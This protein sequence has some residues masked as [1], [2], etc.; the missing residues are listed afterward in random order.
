LAVSTKNRRSSFER[1]LETCKN[2]VV[3]VCFD[4]GNVLVKA[5]HTWRRPVEKLGLELGRPEH[6]D[7]SVFTIP[8]YIPMEAKQ[9][10]V[11]EYLRS[12][13]E[14]LG[15]PDTETAQRLHEAI[16]EDEFPGVHEIVQ[17]IHVKGVETGC[18][19]NNNPIHWDWLTKNGPFPAVIALQR[20]F[21][22][23]EIG[24]NK[25]DPGI[26]QHVVEATGWTP[27]EILY[28]DDAP[29]NVEAALA[30]GWNAH[31]IDPNGDVAGQIRAGL[32]GIL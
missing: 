20:K 5:V 28:F 31:R 1:V 21:S 7:E 23:Y 2:T 27:N 9:V 13:V 32:A 14:Y 17:E 26:F 3:P 10:T 11:D 18:L 22:S 4:I 19:S 12:L 30:Q 25:P 8:T 6:L 24:I 15:L 16:L 29:K